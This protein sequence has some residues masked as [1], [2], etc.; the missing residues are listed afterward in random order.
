MDVKFD[1]IRIGNKRKNQSAEQIV[2]QNLNSFRE[3]I[4][5]LLADVESFSKNNQIH[6][7]LVI[8]AKGYS[9]KMVLEQNLDFQMRN[10][11]KA[12][13]P[14]AMYKGNYSVILDN[15]HN[16]VFY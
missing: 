12:N 7:T 3:A 13:F 2:M 11:L 6:L 8:P 10:L 1:I 14:T 9:V 5:I 15:I 4:R 16:Q